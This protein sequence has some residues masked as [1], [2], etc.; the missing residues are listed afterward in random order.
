MRFWPL[1]KV[2]PN[3]NF[4]TKG[5]LLFPNSNF[6]GGGNLLFAMSNFHTKYCIWF[7]YHNP[8]SFVRFNIFVQI[9][10]FHVMEICYFWKN[11]FFNFHPNSKFP[12]QGNLLFLNYW[13][14]FIF[15]QIVI[16]HWKE[17]CYFPIVVSFSFSSI[18]I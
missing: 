13:I 9:V 18:F 15:V 4:P 12:F 16:F 10:N 5:N 3:S 14:F 2:W 1:N 6:P 7:K 11:V 17:I 8:S